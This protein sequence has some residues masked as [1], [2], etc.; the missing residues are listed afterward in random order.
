MI[1]YKDKQLLLLRLREPTRVLSVIPTSKPVEYKGLAYVAVKH[2][3]DE[4]KVLRNL[5]IPAPSPILHYYDWPGQF[6]PFKAQREA[7]AFMCLE[8]RA[9]NLSEL[10]TGKTLATLWAYDYLR[11]I[12]KV[13]KALVV[14]PLSTLE[15]A[16]G[17]EIFAHFPH[18]TAAVA[19]G[20]KE[21][22]L[23]VLDTDA[24]IYL[25]NHD[26]LKVKGL[27]E[28]LKDRSDIDLI[29]IDEIAQ[30]GRNS[31]TD[32]WKALHTVCNKQIPRKVWGLTGTPTPNLPTDA[33]AQCRL[34]VPERVPP[35]FNRFKESVMRQINQ[36]VWVARDNALETVHEAMQPSVRFTRDECL[37]LPPMLYINKTAPLSKAQH[38]AYKEMVNTLC[39]EAKEGK[40]TAANE[41]VKAQKLIQVACGVVYGSNGVEAVLD[42]G[43]RMKV[44]LDTI[45]E[46]ATKVII[47][48]P[49]VA[50]A[51][52]V[53]REVSFELNKENFT[54]GILEGRGFGKDV[55]LI[56]G[57]ISKNERDRIFSAFQKDVYPKVI[58]AQPAAMSH[59]LTLTAASTIVWFAPIASNETFTQANGRITRAGQ[60][61]TQLIVMIE[62]TDMEAKYYR[63]LKNKQKVQGL[64]LDMVRDSRVAA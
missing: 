19:Y 34:L 56:H 20:S 60:K 58:V 2:G 47:F 61:H 15:R 39:I 42:V 63:R 33:W 21:K 50:V 46:S 30:V 22:R 31:G 43:P 62:G 26:G 57:G 18:L 25:I 3:T 10:G 13:H 52:R 51:E 5:G 40:I 16:W 1:I 48:V 4:V 11:G 8:N 27:L 32:R 38:S 6:P 9:F 54:Q 35:Y 28:A 36:W 45:E 24:D 49:F 7:A 23:K 12:G 44:L 29:V 14:T 59:G 64:L 17:D 53:A 55:E 41:A 37:D